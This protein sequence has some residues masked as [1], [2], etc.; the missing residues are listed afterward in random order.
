M[1]TAQVKE[2]LDEGWSLCLYRK[3]ETEPGEWLTQMRQRLDDIGLEMPEQIYFERGSYR[4]AYDELL[5]EHGLE[6]V[7]HHQE[8]GLPALMTQTE[9][10][11]W[12]IGAW[13]WNQENARENMETAV[14]KGA[15]LVFTIGAKYYYE[16]EQ[17]TK[18]LGVLAGCEETESLY[19]TDVTSA[20]S[21]RGEAEST[22]DAYQK[23]LEAEREKLKA[24][25][26]AVEK[27]LQEAYKKK[28]QK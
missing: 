24:E 8:P 13:G 4:T 5:A 27:K 1:K 16:E 25:I 12:H 21:Y 23:E 10:G 6:V 3:E 19:V 11:I 20:Y 14:E 7:I 22:R 17:F 15:G 18:M 9:E 28:E 26:A 2:L